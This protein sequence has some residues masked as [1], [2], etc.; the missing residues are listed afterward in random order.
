MAMLS[1]GPSGRQIIES[2]DAIV[3]DGAIT[4]SRADDPIPTAREGADD[5]LQSIA[6][7]RELDAKRIHRNCL[8]GTDFQA[9]QGTE[10]LKMSSISQWMAFWITSPM[11]HGDG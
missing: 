4:H 1:I 3:Y 5:L 7:D 6:L 8:H 2:N 9:R 10:Y 11:R